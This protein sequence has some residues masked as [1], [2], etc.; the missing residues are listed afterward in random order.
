M[1]VSLNNQKEIL[2]DGEMV[3][4]AVLTSDTRLMPR[5]YA[6][7]DI[8]RRKLFDIDN[9]MDFRRAYKDMDWNAILNIK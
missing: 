1:K 3:A 5:R 8:K 2:I 9:Y 6:L 4:R 7:I